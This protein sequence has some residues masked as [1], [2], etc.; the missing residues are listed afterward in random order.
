MKKI[1]V[2]I[3]PGSN[4]EIEAVRAC[5]RSNMH[6]EI[7]RWNDDYSKLKNF[8]AYI[9]PGGFSYE[10]RG[11]SGI[12][13]SLDPIVEVVKEQALDG[14]PLLGICNGAQILVETGLIPGLNFEKPE[15]ALAA[16]ERIQK[17]KIMGIGYYND[18]IYIRSEMPKSSSVFNRFSKKIIMR[19]PI[20]HGEGRFETRSQDL[21]HKLITNKQTLFRYCDA[22]GRFIKDFP[23]NPNGA[24]HN[25]AGVCNKEGNILALMPHPER[26]LNGQPIFDSLADHLE[27][28]KKIPVSKTQ[29]PPVSPMR[30]KTTEIA[31]KKQEKKPDI[32]ILIKLIITDNEE[33]TLEQTL[34][35]I[36]YPDTTLE[37][38]ILLGFYVKKKTDLKKTAQKLIESGEVLNLNKEIPTI[39]IG[40]KT[41][42]FNQEKGLTE[43]KNPLSNTF[44]FFVTEYNNYSGKTLQVNLK[45]HLPKNH[46]EKVE[47]GIFWTLRTK[48]PEEIPHILKTHLFSNPHSMKI[49]QY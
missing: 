6:A 17:G 25:L 18:W 40:K 26:T 33:K 41:Y 32:T 42:Q 46:L 21:L 38:Q 23:I 30:E 34:Q 13:A 29:K 19:V 43:S 16:N 39:F 37:R 20:A 24:I 12:I 36:G 31:L 8:D 45:N 15:M 10:D 1:A 5:F 2:I 35:R 28:G 11:R 49:T 7:F 44:N 27:H 14:K 3:F 22:Q 9:I 4:C 48:S 47:R